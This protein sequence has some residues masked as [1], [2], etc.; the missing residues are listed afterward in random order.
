MEIEVKNCNNCPFKVVDYDSEC[1][2]F[3]TV[4]K[5]NLSSFVDQK[6][7][8]IAVYDSFRDEGSDADECD[9]CKN[10]W[11]EYHQ[12]I[13]LN[14]PEPT[15][16]ES[17]CECDRLR[18]EYIDNLPVVEFKSPDWCPLIELKEINIK[19]KN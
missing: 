2:G 17:K 18:Q 6:Y 7:E 11:N 16:D 19:L 15:F 5:C 8:A 3:D 4:E 12:N 14:L 1:V 10:Y 13:K 9:Y